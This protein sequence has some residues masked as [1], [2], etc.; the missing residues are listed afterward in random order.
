M[1]AQT[2]A[3]NETSWSAAP[4]P[5]TLGSALHGLAAILRR[6][7]L[8]LASVAL[9]IFAAA[10]VAVMMVTPR[11]EAVAKIKIDPSQSAAMGQMSEQ[12]SYPDQAIVDTEVQVMNSLDVARRVVQRLQLERDPEFTRKL[13]EL[14]DNASDAKKQARLDAIANAALKGMRA[15]R[16]KATYIV[17]LAYTSADPLRAAAI[18]NAFAEAYIEASLSRRSGTAERQNELLR[19]ELARLGQD[20]AD[21]EVKLA[22][23]RAANGVVDNGAVQGTVAD[24]QIAPLANQLATAQ[25]DAAAAVAKVRAAE[26]QIGSGGIDAVSA[27]LNSDVIRTLRAQRAELLSQ[28]SENLTR[29][30]P[31]H[32]QT[33]KL[34][35][36]V[37]S[38][39]EQIDAEAKRIIGG[40]RADAASAEA[41]AQSLASDLARLRAQQAQTTRSSADAISYAQE[42]Q[43]AQTAYNSLSERVQKVDQAAKSSLSQAQIIEL[44]APPQV[45]SAPR[46]GRLLAVALIGALFTGTGVAAFLEVVS[47][48]VRTAADVQALGIG[49]IAQIPRLTSSQMS[50][51]GPEV[52][53]PADMVVSR[54][55]G[56]YAEAL[57][58]IRG[59]L[60]LG[61][62]PPPQ[63][64]AIVSTL[65]SEGKTVTS[66]SLARVI[67]LSG[68]RTLVIDTDLRHPAIARLA[69]LEP[70]KGIVELLKGEAALADVIVPD[71][72]AN[73]DILPVAR[74]LFSPED[75]F[76]GQAMLDLLH[77]LRDRYEQIIIDTP[78]LLGVT[79]ARTVSAMADATLLAVKWN[80]TPRNAIRSALRMLHN[81]AANL[82]GAILTIVDNTSEA[83]GALYY[84]GKYAKYYADNG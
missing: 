63:T 5:A 57:R 51:A 78:P 53:S 67:A 16:E 43:A 33:L 2:A 7:W 19:K 81:D 55:V 41:R 24:Q 25:S 44:A 17:D 27:V 74:T 59:S 52:E 26:R 76:G 3:M 30:G 69:G 29:Y 75:M 13:P 50:R 73:L 34:N 8:V 39:D 46:K 47:T 18:A 4:S 28:Q 49:V 37:K 66:L 48:G 71:K 68:T 31:R 10:L 79:D 32:P 54:P 61:M 1:D 6:Q 72:V 80:A 58:A 62:Q 15:T 35:E 77:D 22:R 56:S 83:Y 38:M 42:A 12:S 84:S 40:L 70:E 60:M 9:V 11:Y 36:Q 14:A 45:P 23:F 21:A 64:I 82:R 65:P 20:A